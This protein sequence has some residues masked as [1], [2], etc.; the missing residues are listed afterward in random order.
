MEPARSARR[1]L[2]FRGKRGGTVIGP[3]ASLISSATS[4]ARVRA[5]YLG[6]RSR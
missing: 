5:Q 2:L 4:R 3:R 6:A 1:V